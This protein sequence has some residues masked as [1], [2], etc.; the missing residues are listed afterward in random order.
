M[1]VH[2]PK[3]RLHRSI[4]QALIEIHGHRIYLGK[5]N[6][7]ESR[8]KYRQHIARLMASDPIP[9]SGE[10]SAKRLTINE[11][12]LPK[13]WDNLRSSSMDGRRDSSQCPRNC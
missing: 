3:Y 6:S 7:P 10:D 2:V 5:Y 13:R 9:V 11:L 8:E 1:S 12:C 4:G